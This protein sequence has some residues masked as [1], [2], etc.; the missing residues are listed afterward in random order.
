MGGLRDATARHALHRVPRPALTCARHGHTCG[1]PVD[2]QAMHA[3]NLRTCPCRGHVQLGAAL[4]G[5]DGHTATPQAAREQQALRPWAWRQ[6]GGVGLLRVLRQ[7]GN[8]PHTC[9]PRRCR[10]HLA[11]GA[12]SARF[13]ALRARLLVGP[14]RP[15]IACPSHITL[16]SRSVCASLPAPG[17]AANAHCRRCLPRPHL[18]GRLGGAAMTCKQEVSKCGNVH[19]PS[20]PGA[21]KLT[22]TERDRPVVR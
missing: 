17:P 4:P 18:R 2:Q 9:R 14:T 6:G 15:P 20:G 7:T 5:T 16:R 21:G 11:C 12:G 3:C 10:R 8:A 13:L 22:Q 19:L 1:G